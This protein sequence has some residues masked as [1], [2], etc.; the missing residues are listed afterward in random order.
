MLWGVTTN[1][2]SRCPSASGRLKIASGIIGEPADFSSRAFFYP[3]L[4]EVM[5][6]D[7]P[8]GLSLKKDEGSD[9]SLSASAYSK[10]K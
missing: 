4:T 2:K 6:R 5:L 9:S 1:I 3:I 7:P 10:G 8:T